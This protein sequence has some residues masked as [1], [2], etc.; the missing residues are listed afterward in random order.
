[1]PLRERGLGVGIRVVGVV[2]VAQQAALLE[3]ALDASHRALEHAPDVPRGE[4]RQRVED[5]VLSFF[6]VNAIKKEHVQM[7]I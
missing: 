7:W 3:K 1:M 5:D 2:A 4:V 6:L